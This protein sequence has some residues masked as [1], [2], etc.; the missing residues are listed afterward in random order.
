MVPSDSRKAFAFPVFAR[1]ALHAAGTPLLP[2]EDLGFQLGLAVFETLLVERD[3]VYFEA[4]HGARLEAAAKALGIPWVGAAALNQALHSLRRQIARLSGAPER[5]A[6]RVTLSAGVP[7]A[8]PELI[9]QARTPAPL[10]PSG[11]ALWISGQRLPA[12]ACSA[13]KST[14]RLRYTWA[15]REAAAQGA[16]EAL[17]L[18]TAGELAEGSFSNVFLFADGKLRTPPL[19]SG[20]LPGILRAQLVEVLEREPLVL[21]DGRSVELC[22][23][24]L[25]PSVLEQAEELFLTNSIGRLIPVRRILESGQPARELPAAPGPLLLALA[26]RL[27]DLEE[28]DRQAAPGGYTGDPALPS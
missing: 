8:E 20:C 16:Y 6:M 17:L 24:P 9:L 18:N 11:V 22:L 15:L 28:L 12:D 1:G 27:S 5:Y 10:D 26:K 3:H 14:N 25:P 23:E 21:E 13:L 2:V 19:S 4:A 7:G